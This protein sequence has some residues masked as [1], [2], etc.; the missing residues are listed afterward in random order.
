[1]A[2]ATLSRHVVP[3]A[4]GEILVDVRGAGRMSPRPAV[5][6]VHGFKGFKDW[7]MFPPL[8]E[9]LARAGYTAVAYNASG[10]GVDDTGEF[11]WP[12]RFGRNTFS[13]ELADLGSVLDA[14]ERGELGTV[15]PSAIGLVGHSRGGG[16][17]VLQTARDPRVRALV[18]W[19]A[20]SHVN[21]W[22]DA[23]ELERWRA[24]GR[25]DVVNARTGQVLPLYATVLEDVERHR[26]SRLDVETAARGIRVPW[27]LIHGSADTSVRPDEADRLAAAADPEIMRSVRLDGAGHTFGAVHPWQG[28]TADLDTVFRQTVA[29][30]GRLQP[31]GTA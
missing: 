16:M 2:T 15:P 4:L 3:G 11:V 9:Q 12:E 31:G 18:T 19:A 24:Q 27:L 22:T 20:I 13:A 26:G 10:S 25:I 8:A 30:F 7:G 29:W 6:V 28:S 5:V 17:A 1:M 14:L 23:A 21:R